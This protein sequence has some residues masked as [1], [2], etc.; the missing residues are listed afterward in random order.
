MLCCH[1]FQIG[2][3]LLSSAVLLRVYTHWTHRVRKWRIAF[4]DFDGSFGTSTLIE[5]QLLNNFHILVSNHHVN[6]ADLFHIEV[7]AHLVD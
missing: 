7:L 4:V 3:D 2:I 1:V 5:C 6:N